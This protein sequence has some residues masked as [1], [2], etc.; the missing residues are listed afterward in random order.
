MG[1]SD[2]N[3]GKFL[4]WALLPEERAL[5]FRPER[6]SKSTPINVRSALRKSSAALHSP[7]DRRLRFYKQG[8]VRRRIYRL[9]ETERWSG[10]SGNDPGHESEQQALTIDSLQPISTQKLRVL[11]T[12]RHS[13]SAH[14]TRLQ[15]LGC[16]R[17]YSTVRNESQAA[18]GGR[19][20]IGHDFQR[21]LVSTGRLG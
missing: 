7:Q 9:F 20:Q 18:F 3:G 16:F 21:A 6:E 14:T 13:S 11:V 4:V 8:P 5:T 2:V 1:L 12:A 19:K 10:H 15:V 17:K